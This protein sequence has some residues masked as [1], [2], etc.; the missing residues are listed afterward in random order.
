MY[1]FAQT[2][3]AFCANNLQDV[4]NVL[5]DGSFEESIRMIPGQGSGTSLTYFFMLSGSE[6]L[7][8]PDRMVLRFIKEA[9]GIAVNPYCRRNTRILLRDFL[10]I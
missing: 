7:I 3:K 8:K 1:R 9:I 4:P 5:T 2:S 10:T 6:N